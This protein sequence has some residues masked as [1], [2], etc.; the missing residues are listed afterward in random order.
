[1]SRN[2][3][4]ADTGLDDAR[5]ISS[6]SNS[7]SYRMSQADSGGCQLALWRSLLSALRGAG[8]G[9]ELSAA[10]VCCWEIGMDS[11]A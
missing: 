6:C 7:L 5:H 10:S 9:M 8:R 4:V 3:G 11:E 1:V 2:A